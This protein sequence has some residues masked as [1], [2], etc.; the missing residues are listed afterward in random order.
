MAASHNQSR[1]SVC[2]YVGCYVSGGET[3]VV[4]VVGAVVGRS[5]GGDAR[6]GSG[7]GRGVLL[8]RASGYFELHRPVW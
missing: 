3:V 4:V 5:S 1:E 8:V 7:G 2:M 6:D